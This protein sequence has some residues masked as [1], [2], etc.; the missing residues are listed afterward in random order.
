[1]MLG[2]PSMK[3]WWPWQTKNRVAGELALIG[4]MPDAAKAQTYFERALAIARQQQAKS[5]E[6]R[7]AMS[8]E[9]LW[10]PL[11]AS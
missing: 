4:P 2:V 9:R 1:M 6:L 7:V 5:W 11:E 8:L 10:Q 3:Q